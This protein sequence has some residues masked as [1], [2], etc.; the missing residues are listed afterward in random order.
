MDEDANV[1]TGHIK[2]LLRVRR[3]GMWESATEEKVGAVPPSPPQ[4][5][6]G[7]CSVCGLAILFLEH[8]ACHALK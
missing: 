4:S 8:V 7:L 2:G 1:W 6:P 5:P 3:P